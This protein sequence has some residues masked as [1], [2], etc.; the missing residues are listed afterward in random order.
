MSMCRCR[1]CVTTPAFAKAVAELQACIHEHELA[2]Y[3]EQIYTRGAVIKA[4]FMAIEAAETKDQLTLLQSYR[5]SL[6]E[7]IPKKIKDKMGVLTGK[8]SGK[9]FVKVKKIGPSPW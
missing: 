7:G 6:M 9:P 1:Y 2:T 8:K 4:L 5:A 3:S